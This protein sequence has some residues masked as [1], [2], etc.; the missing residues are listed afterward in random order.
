L[1]QSSPV[2]GR[3]AVPTV[4]AGRRTSGPCREC[5]K[6]PAVGGRRAAAD[7][8][9]DE[10]SIRAAKAAARLLIKYLPPNPHSSAPTAHVFNQR[11]IRLSAASL[12]LPVGGPFVPRPIQSPHLPGETFPLSPFSLRVHSKNVVPSVYSCRYVATSTHPGE[13]A[14]K[15][16]YL[17]G[18]EVRTCLGR[19]GFFFWLSRRLY[20]ETRDTWTYLIFQVWSSC[21]FWSLVW[22]PVTAMVVSWDGQLGFVAHGRAIAQIREGNSAAANRLATGRIGWKPAGCKDL[23]NYAVCV[24]HS[25]CG[26][27]KGRICVILHNAHNA[28]NSDS[29]FGLERGHS[30]EFGIP[31]MRSL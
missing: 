23:R 15:E 30:F 14:F 21:G 4:T 8:A 2:S 29:G 6:P 31:P 10:G 20:Y 17:R 5:P 1:K 9:I 16:V 13:N 3:D 18:M 7:S 26:R 24:Y 28:Y 27:R 12:E 11:P 25:C 19:S 22:E